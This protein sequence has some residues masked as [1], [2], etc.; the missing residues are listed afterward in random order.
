MLERLQDELESESDN[1]DN[2]ESNMIKELMRLITSITGV[3]LST[4]ISINNSE[5]VNSRKRRNDNYCAYNKG[6]SS[7]I[8]KNKKGKSKTANTIS[9]DIGKNRFYC[10][11]YDTDSEEES[12]HKFSKLSKVN[13]TE[14]LYSSS[15]ESIDN[16]QHIIENKH[17]STLIPETDYCTDWLINDITGDTSKKK[18]KTPSVTTNSRKGI[19]YRITSDAIEMKLNVYDAII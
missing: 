4:E 8:S 18:K 1:G 5:N 11:S 10:Q 19:T 16:E 15:N 13:F 9:N 6:A 7:V 2:D 14:T 17:A 12:R 3:S